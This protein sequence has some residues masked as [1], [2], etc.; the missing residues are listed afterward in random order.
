[1]D[2]V[3]NHVHEQ[4][5]YLAA[6]PGWFRTGCVC[7]TSGCGWTEQ[8]LECLFHP[9]MPDIDWSSPAAAEQMIADA[10]FWLERY[11]LDG[12]R[13]DAVKHVE[14]LSIRHLRAAIAERFEQAGTRYFLLGETA[15]GWA[16][17]DLEANDVEYDTISRYVGPDGL[18]GQFD[19]VLYHAVAYRVFANAEHGFLH[20]DFW[21]RQSLARYPAGSVMTP[22]VGSHDSQR[23]LTLAEYQGKSSIPD[24]KWPSQGLPAAP[25]SDA[26]YQRAALAFTWVLSLPGAPLLYY[27]DEYG[28]FGATDPDNRHM[29]RGPSARSPR[30]SALAGTLEK[31]LRARRASLALRRG[32]YRTLVAE[33]DVL[34][35]AREVAGDVAVVALNRGDAPVTRGIDVAGP[36][37]D[38]LN[39]VDAEGT[40]A[41]PARG[42]ALFLPR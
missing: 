37:R 32:G 19:F 31:V 33:E 22:F 17:H 30:E 7:G 26:P 28:E 40:I 35:F 13:V 9:Y 36:L 41:I 18:S 1:M 2:L 8:R 11:D 21:T 27:G 10:L 12:F 23:F 29:W 24:H 3:L 15:M 25:A 39:D 14:D 42:A 6:H 20:A 16:G 5:P 38:V 34:V 4:H